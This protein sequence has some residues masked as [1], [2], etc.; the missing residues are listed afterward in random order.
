L[1]STFHEKR[2]SIGSSV[3]TFSSS[4]NL[5]IPWIR[6]RF[7]EETCTI[8]DM[9][10]DGRRA[11]STC[12]DHTERACQLC[13]EEGENGRPLTPSEERSLADKTA[14]N[15]VLLANSIT[16]SSPFLTN[17]EKLQY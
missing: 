14:Q 13:L 6:E 9:N 8:S 7:F 15:P 2:K 17:A 3:K 4:V 11:T 10:L 1:I 5:E 12:R 16:P